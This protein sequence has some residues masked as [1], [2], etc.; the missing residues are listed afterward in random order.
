M[1]DGTVFSTR[2]NVGILGYA[3]TAVAGSITRSALSPGPNGDGHLLTA[4]VGIH[5]LVY[6]FLT[7][8]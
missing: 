6:L 8:F 4:I 7:F 2:S 3:R 1:R 5:E